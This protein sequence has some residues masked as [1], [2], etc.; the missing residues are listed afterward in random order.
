LHVITCSEYPDTSFTLLGDAPDSSPY[1]TADLTFVQ[2]ISQLQGAFS[3]R[4]G[5]KMECRGNK[6]VLGDFFIKVSVV[7]MAT[8][9]KGVL[10]EVR[11]CMLIS[12]VPK[13]LLISG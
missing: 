4:P 5:S 1:V 10:I 2:L 8:S 9:V 6:Y 12:D 13:P 7:T 3:V 11:I